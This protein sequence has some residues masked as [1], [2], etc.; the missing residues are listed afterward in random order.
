M[1]VKEKEIIDWL[2]R[3]WELLEKSKINNLDNMS[4]INLKVMKVMDKILENIIFLLIDLRQYTE[5][6]QLRKK[7]PTIE[8]IVS[9][10]EV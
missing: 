7:R 1:N 3:L 10:S 6:E 8:D 4:K 9:S 2:T 5:K